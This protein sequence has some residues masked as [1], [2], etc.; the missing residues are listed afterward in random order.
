AEHSPPLCMPR[1]GAHPTLHTVPTRRSSDLTRELHAALSA[2]SQF[3]AVMS[4]EIRTPLN[5]ILGTL[6]MLKTSPLNHEQQ[7]QVH[8]IANSG[9]SLLQLIDDILDYTRIEAGKMP[10][11]EDTFRDRKST[12]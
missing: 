2:R 7:Q 8:V 6:D 9:N 10:L 12:R 11:N 3:L 1:T 4:H 5:G